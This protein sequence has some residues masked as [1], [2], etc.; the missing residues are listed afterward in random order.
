MELATLQATI[1]N[2]WEK[3]DTVNPGTTGAVR[4]AVDAALGALDAGK[5]L[6]MQSQLNQILKLLSLLG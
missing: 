4:E 3:R 2:A 1:E 6:V 5:A